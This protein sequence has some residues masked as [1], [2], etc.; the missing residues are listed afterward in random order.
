MRRLPLFVLPTVLFPGTTIPLHVFEPRY[1]QMV[2]RCLEYDKR[3]G[4]LFHSEDLHGPFRVE[5]GWVGSVAELLEFRP[6]PDGRSVMQARGR[7]RFRVVDG[8][9]SA[10]LYH[11]ALVETYEDEPEDEAALLSRRQRSIALFLSLLADLAVPG[12]SIPRFDLDR[13]VSFQL[14]DRIE[15]DAAWQQELLELRAEARRLDEIDA[16]VRAVLNSR[17]QE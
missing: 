16:I 7:E 3:F 12:A 8:V 6:L 10:T 15:I 13:D 17:R 14:A 9:D 5:E 1:R 2:A 11:E 4:L